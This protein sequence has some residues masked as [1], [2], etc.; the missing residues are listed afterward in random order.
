M[1]LIASS[2]AAV[3]SGESSAVDTGAI[4]PSPVAVAIVDCD[5]ANVLASLMAADVSR[6]MAWRC[7]KAL[8]RVVT[9]SDVLQQRDDLAQLLVCVWWSWLIQHQIQI[10]QF[11]G[12]VEQISQT[13]RT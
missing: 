4:V 12:S 2:T 11:V 6:L 1:T 3:V 5:S 13:L 10:L 8:R 9:F 7:R